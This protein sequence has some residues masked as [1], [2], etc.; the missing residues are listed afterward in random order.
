MRASISCFILAS[1]VATAAFAQ[2]A[3]ILP[4]ARRIPVVEAAKRLVQ[5]PDAAPLPDE[6][7]NPF[8][9]TPLVRET[10]GPVRE[11]APATVTDR[12]L[13]ETIA[14][15]IDPTGT[16]SIGGEPFLL[17]GQKRI[18]VGDALPITFDGQQ[19]ELV[20]TAIKPTSFT[21]R[22]RGEELTRSIKPA[23]RP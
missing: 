7:K 19:Y 18:K 9:P 14:R 5:Q 17:F 10:S 13:L 16:V 4:A 23:N 8:S 12:Q 6:L 21:L 1:S 15:Q 11:A 22:L 20:I 3:D 2:K